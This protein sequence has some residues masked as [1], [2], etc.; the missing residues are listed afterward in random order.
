MNTLPLPAIIERL[1][2]LSGCSSAM[3][4]SFLSEF[5]ALVSQALT[6]RGSIVVRGL[7]TFR[8]IEMGGVKSVEFA[9]DQSLASAVN[10]PFAMFEPV[11]LDDAVTGDMLAAAAIEPVEPENEEIADNEVAADTEESTQPEP[12][13][14]NHGDEEEPITSDPTADD[15]PAEKTTDADFTPE[16][17]NDE[18]EIEPAPEPVLPVMDKP[19]PEPQKTE[20]VPP[21]I[22]QKKAPAIENATQ[23]TPEI[24]QASMPAPHEKIIEKERVVE[25]VDRSHNLLHHLLTGLVA[26][27]AGIAIGYF[28]YDK[29][30]LTGVKNVSI[31]AD[32]VQ[33]YHQVKEQDSAEAQRVEQVEA[34]PEAENAAADTEP[35]TESSAPVATTAAPKAEPVAQNKIVTDTV[36]SNRFLTT[37]AQQYYGKKKFWVYIYLE[38][39]DKL[40]DPDKIAANTVVVIPPAEKYDIKP[41]DPKSEEAAEQLAAKIL[42]R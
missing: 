17:V 12:A 3:A 41:G 20:P 1:C 14:N 21:A 22:P 10:A 8:A 33:V 26:L 7:G 30:N 15:V 32:D 42:N 35:A 19:E 6:D 40:T 38:N 23:A 24:K 39:S 36:R 37:M 4:Q 28:A 34:S 31:S 27:I 2:E 5:S 11:E 16:H 18:P 9:P 29:L 13:A 25:V